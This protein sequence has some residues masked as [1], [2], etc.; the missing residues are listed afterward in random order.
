MSANLQMPTQSKFHEPYNDALKI[1]R[2]Y[3]GTNLDAKSRGL[4]RL[5]KRP[6]AG[7]TV[8]VT[9]EQ[10]KTRSMSLVGLPRA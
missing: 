2:N 6:E 7:W 9:E 10:N 5:K 8:A 3:H 4:I 1:T